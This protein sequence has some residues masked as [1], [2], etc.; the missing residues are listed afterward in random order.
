M[1][2][3]CND[4]GGRGVAQVWILREGDDAGCGAGAPG[5]LVTSFG[6]VAKEGNVS[7]AVGFLPLPVSRIP[8]EVRDEAGLEDPVDGG[9]FPG[10]VRSLASLRVDPYPS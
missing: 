1:P 2:H 10:G 3:L 5:V 9:F 8:W 6:R 7:H 4:L